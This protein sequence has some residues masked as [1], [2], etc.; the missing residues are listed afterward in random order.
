MTTLPAYI[1]VRFSYRILEFLRQWYV[2]SFWLVKKR[3]LL[4]AKT[5]NQNLGVRETFN[6]FFQPPHRGETTLVYVLRHTHT[7]FL[8]TVGS[9]FLAGVFVVAL[10][11]YALWLTAPL[12]A[13][14]ELT[15]SIFL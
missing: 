8:A 1:L 13:I 4:F 15:Q 5:L 3:G 7:V 11:L 14:Y 9:F 10:F 6:H 12:V 2:E